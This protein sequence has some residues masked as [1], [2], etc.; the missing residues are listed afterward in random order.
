MNSLSASLFFQPGL[1]AGGHD[2]EYEKEADV[3][4]GNIMMKETSAGKKFF[5]PVDIRPLQQHDK[6][7]ALVAGPQTASYLNNLSGG[8]ALPASEKAFF[9]SAM[10]YDFQMCVFM[11][12][13]LPVHRQNN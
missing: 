13:L 8:K 1:A 4:A 12:M 2:D 7:E 11:Q 6:E 3:V 5:P 9:E 10:R